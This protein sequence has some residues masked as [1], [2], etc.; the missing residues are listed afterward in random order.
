MEVIESYDPNKIELLLG[1]QKK[2]DSLDE[3]NN[4]NVYD[5]TANNLNELEDAKGRL[6]L[7]EIKIQML[8]NR[9]S[10]KYPEV[11][12]LNYKNRKRILVSI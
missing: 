5:E 11:N 2:A 6:R 1:K 10:K 9:I 4:K 8:E 12:F 3:T 7:L